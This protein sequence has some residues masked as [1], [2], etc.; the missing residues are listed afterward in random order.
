MTEWLTLTYLL[1]DFGSCLFV[2]ICLEVFSDFLLKSS[3]TIYFFN[4]T[5]FNI[6]MFVFFPFFFLT[7]ISSFISLWSEKIFD[8]ISIHLN[9]LKFVLWPGM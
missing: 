3:L 9:L 7:L 2:I 8:I 4:S 6:H 5:L 1:T